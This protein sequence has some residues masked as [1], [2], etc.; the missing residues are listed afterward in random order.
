MLSLLVL[1]KLFHSVLLSFIESVDLQKELYILTSE[2]RKSVKDKVSVTFTVRFSSF[3]TRIGKIV[4]NCNVS[5]KPLSESFE[6]LIFS[7]VNIN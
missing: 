6:L 5:Q 1:Q 7:F 3:A 4:I 2:L